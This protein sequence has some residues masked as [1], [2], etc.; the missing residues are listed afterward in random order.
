MEATSRSWAEPN[1]S[2]S[3]LSGSHKLGC[4]WVGRLGRERHRVEHMTSPG[5]G[6][7]VGCSRKLDWWDVWAETSCRTLLEFNRLGVGT[8]EMG[9]HPVCCYATI[10]V[11]CKRFVWIC[12]YFSLMCNYMVR[13]LRIFKVCRSDR[14]FLRSCLGC[15]PQHST[16]V[17]WCFPLF[18]IISLLT[19][20]R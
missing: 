12:S 3:V 13:M 10:S 5:V 15:H 1:L 9:S 4:S 19:L 8:Q 2:W 6:M 16:A 7:R 18:I 20:T 17:S 11:P 14:L